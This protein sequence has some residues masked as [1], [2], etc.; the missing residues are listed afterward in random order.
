MG[1]FDQIINTRRTSK[2]AKRNLHFEKLGERKDKAGQLT[3]FY[4]LYFS[5][6]I[7]SLGGRYLNNH[8]LFG[9]SISQD[10]QKRRNNFEG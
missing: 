7:L 5:S 3:W 10:T 4:Y 9:R 8:A 6:K 1:L 2:I